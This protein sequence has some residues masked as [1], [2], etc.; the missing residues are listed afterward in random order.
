MRNL[1][2]SSE[3][4]AIRLHPVSSD[5]ETTLHHRAR[6]HSNRH[7]IFGRVYQHVAA[8][9]LWVLYSPATIVA[10]VR[11]SLSGERAPQFSGRLRLPH[12]APMG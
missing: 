10:G 6:L 7:A 9:L 8:I 3:S 5:V 12:G 1:I 4:R 11:I 2:I